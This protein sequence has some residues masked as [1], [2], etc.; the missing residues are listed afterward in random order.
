MDTIEILKSARKLI[1]KPENWTQ[2]TR[3]RNEN[4][5][6]VHVDDPSACRFCI[7]GAIAKVTYPAPTYSGEG[8]EVLA[9]LDGLA[10]DY[11]GFSCIES[12]NDYRKRKHEEVLEFFDTA[13]ANL[14][15]AQCST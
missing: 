3:A 1:E 6:G 8:S 5:D 13:I 7:V 10:I 12:F 4:G 11:Y 9:D 15:A 2:D 14:E